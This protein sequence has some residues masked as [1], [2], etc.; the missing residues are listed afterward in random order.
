LIE[1]ARKGAA[2]YWAAVVDLYKNFYVEDMKKGDSYKAFSAEMLKGLSTEPQALAQ[3]LALRLQ[4]G[5]RNLDQLTLR[6]R[7]ASTRKE[8]DELIRPNDLEAAVRRGTAHSTGI[9]TLY[10][11]LLRDAG[12]QPL[13]AFVEDRENGVLSQAELNINQLD[14]ILFGIDGLGKPRT[15]LDPAMRF[16]PPTLILPNY[17]ATLALVVDSSTWH[18]KV[19]GIQSQPP[20][21]NVRQDVYRLELLPDLDKV[22]LETTFR[23]YDDYAERWACVA[24]EPKEQD[25]KLRDFF[26]GRFGAVVDRVQVLNAADIRKPI[27]WQVEAR[28]DRAAGRRRR[29]D[30]FPLTPYALSASLDLPETR[31]DAIVVPYLMERHAVSRFRLPPGYRF[32]GLEPYARSN[33][34]GSV[35]LKAQLATA[36]VDPEVEATLDVNVVLPIAGGTHWAAFR[37]FLGWIREAGTTSLILER[38]P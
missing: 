26:E 10:F 31:T 6:E 8:A 16:A 5:I 7:A 12:I 33:E 22:M 9:F 19:E 35:T 21:T 25:R 18:G 1:A 23:G 30:P 3:E 37:E 15:W 2:G 17:Q 11:S 34:F 29:V 38:K 20:S 27:Q 13:L 36:S 24:L 4:M 32:T 14:G 28:L